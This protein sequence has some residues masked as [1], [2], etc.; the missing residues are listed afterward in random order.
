MR[1]NLLN[2]LNNMEISLMQLHLV[3]NNEQTQIIE[4]CFTADISKRGGLYKE[5]LLAAERKLARLSLQPTCRQVYL[6][7]EVLDKEG[8]YRYTLFV[9]TEP[10]VELTN[11]DTDRTYVDDN[12][13]VFWCKGDEDR[14]RRFFALVRTPFNQVREHGFGE[15]MGEGLH[16]TQLLVHIADNWN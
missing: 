16:S 8:N 9:P 5:T 14:N 15:A 6:L 4:S 11:I 12:G 3:T 2:L 13:T 1:T 7:Q 10:R